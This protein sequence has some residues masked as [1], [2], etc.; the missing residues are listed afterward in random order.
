MEE[1]RE[2]RTETEDPRH[3]SYVKYALAD[4][5]RRQFG[6]EGEVIAEQYAA[7]QNPIIST[8]PCKY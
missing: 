1:I 5:L 2:R 8:M 6:T 4:I 7:Y 3:S